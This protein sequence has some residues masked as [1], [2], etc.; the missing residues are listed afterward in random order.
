MYA[1]VTSKSLSGIFESESIA[2]QEEGSQVPASQ[3]QKLKKNTEI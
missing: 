3:S 2:S 1:L